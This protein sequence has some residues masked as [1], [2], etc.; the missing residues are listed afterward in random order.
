MRI[1]TSCASSGIAPLALRRV[2]SAAIAPPA[3][4]V[5]RI[6]IEGDSITSGQPSTPN[7]FH[8]YQY[9]D[10]RP[11]LFVEVRAQ[12]S[13]VVGSAANLNDDGN[14]L[15]GNVAEDMAYAPDLVTTMIGANDMSG[16]GSQATYRTNLLAWYAAIK[17]ERPECRV[18]W[19]PPIAYN[20]T[21]TPHPTKANFDT[22]RA[23]VLADARDPA[24]WGQWADYYLPMGEYPDF[25]DAALAAPLFGDSVHPSAAGQ[26]LLYAS[27][28]TAVDSIVDTAR[29][30]STQPYASVWP[31]D[32]ANLA[33]STQIVR[34]FL[35][36]GIAH[37]GLAA[38]V[39]ISGAGAQVRL[40]GGSYGS[41]TGRIYNGDVIDLRVTTSAASDTPV[42]L[43]LTIGSETRTISYRTVAAVDPVE[44]L[45]GGI[46]NIPD[47]PSPA[48]N[49]FSGVE[50]PESGIAILGVMAANAGT[51]VTVDG[52]AATLLQRQERSADRAIEVWAI[53]VAAG[54]RT[55]SV[56]YNSGWFARRIV[57]WG[58][59]TGADPTP[60]QA[61]GSYPLDQ[62]APHL[63][64]A[65]TVPAN[66]LAL[67]WFMQTAG[68]TLTPA[69][70][71]A[72]T[73]FIAQ[74]YGLYQGENRGCAWASSPPAGRPA[75]TSCSAASRAT[76]SCSRRRGHD[77]SR[78]CE[79]PRRKIMHCEATKCQLLA[80]HSPP[81]PAPPDGEYS[82]TLHQIAAPQPAWFAQQAKGP[83]H[84]DPLDP[85]RRAALR[86]A[87]E[88]DRGPDAKCHPT[89]AATTGDR[90]RDQFALRRTNGEKRQ[91]GLFVFHEAGDLLVQVGAVA[92]AHRRGMLDDPRL[93]QRGL[94]PGRVGGRATDKCHDDA[95][96]ERSRDQ[97]TGQVAARGDRQVDT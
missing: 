11:D 64:P 53:P 84:P 50:F 65:V 17:A 27:Y 58:V 51:I 41:A 66:G 74:D 35:V 85:A 18:A 37:T 86:T 88:F 4:T 68:S 5:E 91:L 55:I 31:V 29:A 21:G 12:G 14:S 40:N 10:S 6:V 45:H 70:C 32:E 82:R 61:V 19:S 63:A 46:F 97:L 56:T 59:L 39:T 83:F 78:E 22:Q 16:G 28:K 89:C 80:M 26:S 60:V 15:M 49:T 73:E 34:R 79:P 54:S 81:S 47:E 76:Q 43:N 93:G 75:S 9:A 90:M 23:L 2:G 67:A 42:A 25:P 87:E 44:Y 71:N 8:S 94:Q 62:S 13:R 24:V 1:D 52:V 38:G 36:A 92:H 20:P 33:A 48:T 96:R 3:F 95:G 30:S 72:Q 7:G 57:T 69:T 77:Y